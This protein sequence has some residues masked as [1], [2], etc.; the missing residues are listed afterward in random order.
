MG[1]GVGSLAR[2]AG[3]EETELEFLRRRPGQHGARRGR[4]VS[5][6]VLGMPVPATSRVGVAC[7]A[8]AGWWAV[9]TAAR[10]ETG[11]VA[12]FRERVE[13]ILREHCY[14]CHSHAA[15]KTRGGLTLDSRGGWQEGG[16]LGPAVVPGNPGQSLMIRA[17]RRVDPDLAMPP[18]MPL[19]ETAVGLLE[20][21][22]RRGAPDPRD[23]PEGART[24]E[25]WWALRPLRKPPVP[26]GWAGN[27]IDAFVRAALQ[28]RGQD[29]APE[30]DRRVLMRRMSVGLHGVL[31]SPAEVREVLAGPVADAMG[32]ETGRRLASPRYGERWARHWLDVVHFAETHGHD[33]DRPR[34]TAWRYRDYVIEAFNADTPYARF[35]EEQ[36]AADVLHPDEP[37]LIPALGFLAA[38]P[39]DESSLRDIREDTLDREVG[40]YLD[41]DDI[42]ANVA[43]TFLAV[44][45]HCA[46]CHD[47]KFDPISQEDYYALQA[48]FAG[49]EKA[50]RLFDPDPATH[51]ARQFWMRLEVAVDRGDAEL[52][53]RLMTP[54]LGDD[55][56]R[57]EREAEDASRAWRPLLR[58]ECRAENGT[59]FT[60]LPDGSWRATGAHPAEETCIVEGETDLPRVTAVRLD[61]L[62]DDTL[63]GRGPGRAE[64]GNLHLTGFKAWQ[65][66]VA[67]R[68]RSAAADFEQESWGIAAAI[69][70]D[71]RT[72]WGIHPQTGRPH[73][74]VFEFDPAGVAVGQSWRFVLEQSHGRQHTLGRFRL[75]V[76]DRLPS[77][78]WMA[79]PAEVAA[80]LARDRGARSA[81]EQFSV[82]A[83]YLR[84]RI[85]V[86]LARLP[87]PQRVYAGASVFP[88][89]AGQKPTG[90]PRRVHVLRRGEITQ[91][92]EE[93]EP[94]AL[95]CV[96]GLPARFGA[97]AEE[98]ERRAALARWL[99]HRDHPLTWRA[100]VNRVWQYHFGRGL[101]ETPND[102][103]RMGAAPSHPEL[104]DWLA[105][106]FRDDLGGSLKG[107][108]ALIVGSRTWRQV[109]ADPLS[110]HPFQPLRRRLD[111]ETFR[112]SLLAMAGL[113]DLTQGGPSV[114]QFVLSDGIHVTPRVDYAAFDVDSAASRRRAIYRFLF[115]TLPDP[116]M[117]LLDA[118]SGDQSTPVRGETFS[119]LQSLA[120]MNHPWVIRQATHLAAR[121]ES[122][123][124][125]THTR[126]RAL[127]AVVLLRDPTA[128]ELQAF[129]GHAE[130]FGLAEAGRVL[131]NSNEFHFLD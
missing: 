101:V 21:W 126:V 46:R 131:L 4:R 93:A 130:R 69:D 113:L 61:V 115:R 16:G 3:D 54:A 83:A 129:A 11:D 107:L 112:D 56:A 92:Q 8:L 71:P 103:G 50:E 33:Q 62:A 78:E 41:R 14:P 77:N 111:A 94:G 91:P 28:A 82:T 81:A 65:G 45:V 5:R 23:P 66:E 1:K 58:A 67:V 116:L 34:E 128:A 64:N 25:D 40:R 84:R 12:F 27:P 7:L 53:D 117:D 127:F 55:L 76:T 9:T 68:L 17:I 30:A 47:H 108:H 105:V 80:V 19:E 48:V 31:P 79:L 35:I 49:T 88:P 37:G 87:E 18:S 75:S 20:E 100:I 70:G 110:A 60:I 29:L 125:D 22:V 106:T 121:V 39:W 109:A 74:A 89:N 114:K 90:R 2:D 73:A 102:F 52:L 24:G 124:D 57:W 10:S 97:L 63:P 51:A 104:L 99:S 98:G 38:G 42:V 95:S 119:A 43:S 123:G 6:H 36:V 26:E 44:T 120:L 59:E 72:G 86:E 13:P 96:P 85:R 118:P 15:G 32:S 122:L